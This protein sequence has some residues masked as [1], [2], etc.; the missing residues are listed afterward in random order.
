MRRRRATRV[1]SCRESCATELI[2]K[3]SDRLILLVVHDVG[4]VGESRD[5]GRGG[6]RLNGVRRRY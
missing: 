6:Q 1:G 2:E 5:G 3:R 4:R